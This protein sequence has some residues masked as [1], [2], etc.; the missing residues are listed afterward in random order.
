[1]R[2]YFILHAFFIFVGNQ[3]LVYLSQLYNSFGSISILFCG[4]MSQ[5]YAYEE[6]VHIG[7]HKGSDFD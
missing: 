6:K 1:M 5:W 3:G 7:S 4:E 2:S